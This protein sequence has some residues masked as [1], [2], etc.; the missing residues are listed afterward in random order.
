MPDK[1]IT[2]LTA[3]TSPTSDDL[4]PTINDPAGTPANRKVT[5]ANAI[6]KAHG[7]SDG[8]VKVATGTMSVVAATTASI[9]ASTDKNYVTDAQVTVI[10]NASGTNSGD[11]TITLTGDVTGAGTGSFAATIANNA[12]TLA[13]M[14]TMATDSI[15]GRLTAATGNVEVLSAANV[16]TIINVADGANN[17]VHPNHSGDVTSVAD[18]AQTIAANAVTNAKAAQMATK[19]YK[20]RTSALTGN[21]EDVAVATLKTDLILVKGDVGLGDVDNTTDASKPVSTAQQTALDLKA[22]LASPTFTGTV[23]LPNSQ[24][25][26]TP[27]LGTPTSATLTNATGLP[28]AGLVA[29]TATAIGVGSVE[30]GHASDTTL[31]RSA[32]GTLAVEGIR[33]R[34]TTPLVVSAASYT[35]DT[36]TS[37]NMDNLDEFII[38]AQAGALLF[39]SP[40]GTLVQGRSL[41][42]RIKDNATARALTWNAVFRAMGTALPST[43][44]LSKTLYLGFKYNSTDTKWDLIASAQEI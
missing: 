15:L 25:L 20:G 2:G 38:T 19:T 30:L 34:T 43:T 44:V 6:T 21:A 28:I 12:V 23:V 11:Q 29:S 17:Y 9:A 42:I 18:G 27:V 16:R 8:L 7:L 33:V 39:N 13:K 5:L 3:D 14:A 41:I 36:G 4:I 24:A 37:L 26:V 10:G 40:G 35:T 32:A 22:D 31:S 1:K